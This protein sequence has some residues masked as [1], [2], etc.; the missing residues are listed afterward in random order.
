MSKNWVN[1]IAKMHAHYGVNDVVENMDA[2]TLYEFLKFRLRFLTEELNEL[3]DAVYSSSPNIILE[4]EQERNYWKDYNAS[5]EVVD[6]LIDLCV[7][8]IGTLDALNIDSHKAWNEVL[9]AN[10][11]KEVGIKESRPN[12]FGLPDLVKPE[13]WVGPN[14]NGNYGLLEKL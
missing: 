2:D 4:T 13:G 10:M 5:E 8:A 1:D 7:V 9:R 3:E 6:A 14:H 12:P 11:Q